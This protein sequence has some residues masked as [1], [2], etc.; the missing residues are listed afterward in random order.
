MT[1]DYL[2]LINNFGDNLVRLYDFEKEEAAKFWKIL[3]KTLVDDLQVLDL[4]TVP[5][6]QAKNCNLIFRLSYEDEGIRT[7]NQETFYCD[8]TLDGYINMLNLVKPFTQK[9]TRSYQYLYD[10]DSLTDL[11]FSPF[12]TWEVEI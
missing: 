6:I 9:N 12:G 8:L 4:A 3:K 1:L 2:P 10:V 11:L 7:N 5:F